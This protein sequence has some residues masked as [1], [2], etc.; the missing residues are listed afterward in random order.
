M[1]LIVNIIRR[2]ILRYSWDVVLSAFV[3]LI[4]CRNLHMYSLKDDF[5]SLLMFYMYH[6]IGLCP[7]YSD[8]KNVSK[9]PT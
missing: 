2:W 4:N 5:R 6:L 3:C 7:H 8:M 1:F 9:V